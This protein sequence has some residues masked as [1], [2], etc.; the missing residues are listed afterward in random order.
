GKA[1]VP[2][3]NLLC[4]CAH[5][6]RLAAL[7]DRSRSHTRFAPIPPHLRKIGVHI[8]TVFYK[9]VFH[10]KEKLIFK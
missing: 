1:G 9:K 2:P 8:T 5:Y 6:V 3:F 10:L 4:K 7:R